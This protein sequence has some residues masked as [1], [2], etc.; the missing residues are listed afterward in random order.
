MSFNISYAPFVGVAK[1]G[2]ER[3]RD[4]SNIVGYASEND[5]KTNS[6][7]FLVSILFFELL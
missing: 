2:V 5:G 1:I 4:S 7:A 3:Q 6:F